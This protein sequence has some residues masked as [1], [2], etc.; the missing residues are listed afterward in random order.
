MHELDVAD[1]SAPM[2]APTP[3][4]AEMAAGGAEPAQGAIFAP[5]RASP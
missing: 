4:A 2:G 5:E 1:G 3:T